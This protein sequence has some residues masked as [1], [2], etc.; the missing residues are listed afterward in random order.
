MKNCASCA[1]NLPTNAPCLLTSF[2]PTFRCGRWR[3]FIRTTTREFSRISG[4]GEKKLQEF[5]AIFLREIAAHLATNARQIFADDSFVEPAAPLPRRAGL[6]DTARET[7]HFFKQGR[8]VPEIA[9]IRGLKDGTIYSHLEEA[10]LAGE[11]VDVNALVSAEA[12][13]EITAMFKKR[14]LGSLG[15]VVEALGGKYSYGECRVVRAALQKP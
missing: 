14:G 15:L 11:T 5:G 2:S 4:V 12:Q 9:R 7:L 6:G 10:M 1:N 8:T 13:R 3:G